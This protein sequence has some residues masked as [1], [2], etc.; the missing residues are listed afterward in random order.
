M[1]KEKK[2]RPLEESAQGKAD[3][4]P[5][6]FVSVAALTSDMVIVY[7]GKI[8]LVQSADKVTQESARSKLSR[9]SK[10]AASFIR[11]KLKVLSGEETGEKIE[12]NFK[13]TEQVER[14]TGETR[15]L[16]YLYP[17]GKGFLFLDAKDLGMKEIPKEK[18][19]ESAS[20]LKEG[21]IVG[22]KFYNKELYD[23]TFPPFLELTVASIAKS[24]SSGQAA[25]SLQ[26]V[27]L[28]TG[29]T[30][31]VPSFVGI[32]DTVEVSTTGFKF[33]RRV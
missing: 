2:T 5:A 19:G 4:P 23:F 9:E 25:N 6:Q 29:A 32:G 20:F 12:K 14:V 28:D 15:D 1:T 31:E 27:T 13:M 10:E 24:T 26:M 3:N 30:L 17:E 21:V 8:C 11:A 22:A 16:V 18:I 33:S 7:G